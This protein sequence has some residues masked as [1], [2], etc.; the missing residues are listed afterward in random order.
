MST[1]DRQATATNDPFV[2]GGVGHRALPLDVDALEDSIRGV[3]TRLIEELGNDPANL[4]LI[5]SVA[6]GADRLLID[7]AHELAI[8]YACVLPCTPGCFAEDFSTVAS[9]ETYERHLAQAQAVVFPRIQPAPG[10]DGYLWVS[11]YLLEHAD[12]MVAVWNGENGNGPGGTADTV[13]L[14]RQRQIPV[15]WISAIPPHDAVIYKDMGQ[16]GSASIRPAI[17]QSHDSFH[18]MGLWKE[19]ED[20]DIVDAEVPGEQDLQ[21]ARKR[22][23]IA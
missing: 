4:R 11:R 9:I 20:G 5:V 14:A 1:S 18:M 21:I 12:L 23:R 7:V 19:I 2:L 6:E 10:L 17:D 16:E 3:F 15:L 8:P 13:A 22:R